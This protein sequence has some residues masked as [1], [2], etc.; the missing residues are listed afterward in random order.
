MKKE[1]DKWE[2]IEKLTQHLKEALSAQERSVAEKRH[3]EY[4]VVK[5]KWLEVET[6]T[7]TNRVMD[8][9]G[10]VTKQRATLANLNVNLRKGNN[11]VWK[12]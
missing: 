5:K 9:E 6:E 2:E 1:E 7:L 10:E 8:F 12:R 4:D 3:T 11:K